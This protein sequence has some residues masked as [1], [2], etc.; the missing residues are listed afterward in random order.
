MRKCDLELYFNPMAPSNSYVGRTAQLTSRRCIL[1]THSTIIYTEYFKRAAYSPFFS[2][3][4][5]VY[6]II[7]PYLVPVLFTF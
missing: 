5:A 6:F 7:L 1:N 4:N 3:K 2:L